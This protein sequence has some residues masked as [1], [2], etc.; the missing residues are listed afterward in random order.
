MTPFWLF[1]R[2]LGMS[3]L[4]AKISPLVVASESGLGLSRT[5]SVTTQ[6]QVAL[7]ELRQ[8]SPGSSESV[9]LIEIFAGLGGLRR[10]VEHCDVFVAI[11]IAVEQDAPA[12][13]VLQAAWP[14]VQLIDRVANLSNNVRTWVVGTS[15]PSHLSAACPEIPRLVSLQQ[16]LLDGQ[17]AFI[18][19]CVS[20]IDV[21]IRDRASPPVLA[22]L[23]TPSSRSPFC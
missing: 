18:P 4:R 3:D 7:Q 6:G 21:D 14:D 13:R 23:E 5:S 15:M 10:A 19:E 9:G 20:N 8:A 2:C 11:H 1:C 12:Q 16:Q 17:V 22:I